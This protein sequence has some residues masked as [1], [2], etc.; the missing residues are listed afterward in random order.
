[1]S[2]FAFI[3]PSDDDKK[4]KITSK[5]SA[6]GNV[7]SLSDNSTVIDFSRD[8]QTN[9]IFTDFNELLNVIKINGKPHRIISFYSAFNLPTLEIIRTQTNQ[10]LSRFYKELKTPVEFALGSLLENNVFDYLNPTLESSKFELVPTYSLKEA[11]DLVDLSFDTLKMFDKSILV[12]RLGIEPF[13]EYVIV[14][15]ADQ[16]IREQSAIG[17]TPNL[18]LIYF[19]RKSKCMKQQFFTGQRKHFSSIRLISDTFGDVETTWIGNV[20]EKATLVSNSEIMRICEYAENAKNSHLTQNSHCELYRLNGANVEVYHVQQNIQQ[21][22]NENK[23]EKEEKSNQIIK[24]EKSNEQPATQPKTSTN[25]NSNS[26]TKQV[27]KVIQKKQENKHIE[28]NE[29]N[30][31]VEKIVEKAKQNQKPPPKREQKVQD[32]IKSD[33][34]KQQHKEIQKNQKPAP[35]ENNKS[36]IKQNNETNSNAN[37]NISIN[38]P[39]NSESNHQINDGTDESIP[40]EEKQEIVSEPEKDVK[41]ENETVKKEEKPTK[42]TDPKLIDSKETINNEMIVKEEKQASISK[43]EFSASKD[44]KKVDEIIESEEK[45]TSISEP[46]ISEIKEVKQDVVK[47]Q[48]EEKQANITKSET[49]ASK[50][51][52]K[53]GKTIKNEEKQKIISEPKAETNSPIKEESFDE[54]KDLE[55]DLDDI[56]SSILM[57]D[58]MIEEQSTELSSIGINESNTEKDHKSISKEL[59]NEE[60]DLSSVKSNEKTVLESQVKEFLHEKSQDN[61]NEQNSDKES[62]EIQAESSTASLFDPIDEITEI[63]QIE[64]KEESTHNNQERNQKDDEGSEII[65]E[66]SSILNEFDESFELSE[67][68]QSIFNEIEAISK[69]NTETPENH[70]LDNEDKSYNSQEESRRSSTDSYDSHSI[71]HLENCSSIISS[72]GYHFVDE[73]SLISCSED[74]DSEIQPTIF[75]KE[76]GVELDL[77]DIE[78]DQ[79][80]KNYLPGLLSIPKDDDIEQRNQ[81]VYEDLMSLKEELIEQERIPFNH[82]EIANNLE[83]MELAL[84]K[85]QLALFQAKKVLQDP[86]SSILQICEKVDEMQKIC[87]DIS[88]YMQMARKEA[89]RLKERLDET[90]A[91]EEDS[92]IKLKYVRNLYISMHNDNSR[93][94][95]E[96]RRKKNKKEKAPNEYQQCIGELQKQIGTV[97]NEIAILSKKKK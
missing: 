8:F 65:Q 73:T 87:D 66:C 54:L 45:T 14:P 53:R 77:Q 71:S 56:E 16:P 22:N 49:S 82:E 92:D 80:N 6:N 90:K 38:E 93:M 75:Y 81:Q 30:N 94:K 67:E 9:G 48:S 19:L 60:K 62:N 96:I 33:E 1:M 34:T 76:K 3:S 91:E 95:A 42:N 31:K 35:I 18:K 51:S 55:Q 69:I 79:P 52:G 85:R 63:S 88:D 72:Q 13:I 4:G 68:E 43:P 59:N 21:N 57:M 86:N 74:E 47:I 97:Q 24:Q 5:I 58:K 28:T 64:K 25:T 70:K 36:N 39:S 12:L 2:V 37:I 84:R 41:Q 89:L 29:V 46:E 50:N 15:N 11:T 83:D 7:L 44:V 26:D 61:S 78:N 23:E 32:V 27:N 10:I 17:L 20:T 40:C